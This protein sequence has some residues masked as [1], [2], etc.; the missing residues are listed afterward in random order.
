M[1]SSDFFYN[2]PTVE[3]IVGAKGEARTFYIHKTLAM[4]H[5]KYFATCLSSN[6]IEG[7]IGAVILDEDDPTAFDAFALWLYAR[8][9]DITKAKLADKK[10][11]QVAWYMLHAQAYAL[12]NKLV[13]DDFKREIVK[14]TARMLGDYDDIPM[15]LVIDMARVIYDGTSDKD[16]REM[17]ELIAAYCASRTG[18]IQRD[19]FEFTRRF[20]SV[21]EVKELTYCQQADF[22]ADVMILLKPAPRL[23]NTTL[24]SRSASTVLRH[25]MISP[26]GRLAKRSLSNQRPK[27]YFDVSWEGPVLDVNDRP[28][29]TVKGEFFFFL[30]LHHLAVPQ[31]EAFSLK[32]TLSATQLPLTLHQSTQKLTRSLPTEQKGRISFN[33][34]YN[35][36][37]MTSE[38]FRALCTGEKGYGYAGSKFHRIIPR[39][40]LQGGD[41]TRGNVSV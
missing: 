6:F 12:G 41:F 39:F 16:G 11:L 34:Y 18:N 5:S 24:P 4:N 35:V 1:S 31:S 21:E 19:N 13:A 36:V 2:S 23:E 15:S 33:L 22:L 26:S 17:R 25:F 8:E 20:F 27:T 10:E 38:N 29:L 3:V 14:K 37:P 40:M 32:S 30:L 7:K 9:Y 28:T